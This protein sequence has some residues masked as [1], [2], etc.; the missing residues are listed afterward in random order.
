MQKWRND[1]RAFMGKALSYVI[2]KPIAYAYGRHKDR[3]AREEQEFMQVRYPQL[4]R[5]MMDESLPRPPGTREQEVY[6]LRQ[7][8]KEWETVNPERSLRLYRFAGQTT[9]SMIERSRI[10]KRIEYVEEKIHSARMTVAWMASQQSRQAPGVQVPQPSTLLILGQQAQPVPPAELARSHLLSRNMQQTVQ[11][12]VQQPYITQ[13]VQLFAP[14]PQ[15][16]E[17][18]VSMGINPLGL[19][20]AAEPEKPYWAD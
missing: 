20:H 12:S 10:N 16:P 13:P 1:D 14:P 17:P 19:A 11:Q 15:M 7:A 18:N 4:Y 5:E 9:K 6:N 3:K 2:I 8:G